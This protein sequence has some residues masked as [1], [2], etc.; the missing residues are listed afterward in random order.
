MPA[1]L[2]VD[3]S[4]LPPYPPTK[5]IP[6]LV[7]KVVEGPAPAPT[8]R[9]EEGASMMELLVASAYGRPSRILR[10]QLLMQIQPIP[11][12]S[13]RRCNF[14]SLQLS[15]KFDQSSSSPTT[16]SLLPYFHIMFELVLLQ[17]TC[18]S[19]IAFAHQNNTK[20]EGNY[21]ARHATLWSNLRERN[22]LN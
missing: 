7:H 21:F 12:N 13:V 5:D 15:S 19:P 3:T 11:V 16:P 6:T 22:I 18:V 4:N 20:A 1:H 9:P 14:R 2:I 17:Q 8:M 10:S